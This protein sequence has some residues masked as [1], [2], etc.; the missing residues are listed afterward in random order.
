ME[1][2]PILNAHNKEEYPPMNTAKHNNRPGRCIQWLQTYWW[3]APLLFVLL[4]AT[5]II[6]LK[7]G[8]ARWIQFLAIAVWLLSIPCMI[9]HLVILIKNKHW[10]KFISSLVIEMVPI[11]IVGVLLAIKGIKFTW[12]LIAMFLAWLLWPFVDPTDGFGK[13]HPIPEGL[14]YSI[15]LNRQSKVIHGEWNSIYEEPSVDSTDAASYL[16]IWKD[17]E[18]GR[19]I[20]D[21]SY[22]ALPAGTVFLKCYEA[23]ENI[24]LSTDVMRRNTSVPC[25]ATRSFSTLVSKR[26]FVIYE[27]DWEDYYAVRVEVWHRDSVT[28]NEQKLLEKY[29]RM[30]GWM[31]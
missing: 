23:S 12:K 24:P 30:D 16:Q 17:F 25:S 10:F 18:G 7:C 6:A 22:P 1:Q 27:G 2:Q 28:H 20:Y 3:T 11:G 21:F 13:E 15:P 8:Y 4:S 26:D 29:Y 9:V 5:V 31:R 19:Y 14:E